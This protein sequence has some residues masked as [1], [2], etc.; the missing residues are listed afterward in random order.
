MQPNLGTCVF[1]FEVCRQRRDGL[2]RLQQPVDRIE[3]GVVHGHASALLIGH[4][5]DFS[6]GIHTAVD[7]QRGMKEN[8]AW[9]CAIRSLKL[10]SANWRTDE[11]A[12]LVPIKCINDIRPRMRNQDGATVRVENHCVGL[13]F[14]WKS[15]LRF[16]AE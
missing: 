8:M 2:P 7:A 4:E 12:L 1:A 5:S 13:F 16:L 14:G 6:L 10:K 9:P 15:L 11:F 3:N